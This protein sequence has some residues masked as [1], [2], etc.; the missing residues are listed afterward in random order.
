MGLW[1]SK[2][3]PVRFVSTESSFKGSN[4]RERSGLILMKMYPHP[5]NFSDFWIIRRRRLVNCNSIVANPATASIPLPHLPGNFQDLMQMIILDHQFILRHWVAMVLLFLGMYGWI[6]YLVPRTVLEARYDVLISVA[7]ERSDPN[8]ETWSHLSFHL[9]FMKVDCQVMNTDRLTC[10]PISATHSALPYLHF[11]Q[12][13]SECSRTS[14]F[15]QSEIRS[16]PKSGRVSNPSSSTSP[17]TRLWCRSNT[18]SFHAW[19]S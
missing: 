13:V 11:K 2:D 1:Y 8:K 7:S 4:H 19:W 18:L 6:V 9:Y 12:I 14:Q 17:R 3:W 16:K 15:L 10:M 5:C